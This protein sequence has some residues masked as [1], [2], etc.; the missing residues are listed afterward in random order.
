MNGLTKAHIIC[1]KSTESE[2]LHGREP[3]ISPLLIRPEGALKGHRNRKGSEAFKH[4]PL[5]QRGNQAGGLYPL[6]IKAFIAP[7]LQGVIRQMHKFLEGHTALFMLL[8]IAKD[9]TNLLHIDL[10]PFT[11][12]EH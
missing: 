6:D 5:H 12:E 11:T 2:C 7:L 3:L 10:N 4:S 9:L 8:H 1:Q